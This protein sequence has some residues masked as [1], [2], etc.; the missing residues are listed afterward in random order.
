[1]KNDLFLPLWRRR[2]IWAAVLAALFVFLFAGALL[3]RA[4]SL[5]REKIDEAYDEMTIDFRL[6]PG[7]VAYGS[8]FNLRAFQIGQILKMDWYENMRSSVS[9]PGRV[10]QTYIKEPAKDGG[11]PVYDTVMF[12]VRVVWTADPTAEYGEPSDGAYGDGVACSPALAE[13]LECSVG[14][15]IPLPF[16]Y[17]AKPSVGEAETAN[18]L[19]RL[20]AVAPGI[21]DDTVVCAW[22]TF[23]RYVRNQDQYKNNLPVESMTFTVKPE[24]NRDIR[25]LA[26]TVQRTVNTPSLYD[27]NKFVAVYYNEAEIKG[28]MDPLER[29]QASA[30]FFEK[31]FRTLLPVVVYVLEA[32]AVLFLSNEFG[33]RRLLGDSAARVFVRLWLPVAALLAAGY[34]VS[35]LI[36]ALCGLLPYADIGT[37]LLHA[38]GSLLLTALPSAVLCAINPLTLLKER[39]DE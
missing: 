33:V 16:T 15:R 7:R 5:T 14:D 31:L 13:K 28:T 11:F 2:N 36:L 29:Q 1:M 23:E 10:F 12:S 9:V 19:L 3:S 20:T 39:S 4:V 21:P 34:G 30:V 27:R 26:D 8:T 32:V 18:E 24:R 25:E 22:E 17:L 37:V 38:A 6:G 35:V